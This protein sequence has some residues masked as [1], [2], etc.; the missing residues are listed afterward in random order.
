MKIGSDEKGSYNEEKGGHGHHGGRV[1]G[2]RKNKSG[3]KGAQPL[4]PFNHC[5]SR[6]YAYASHA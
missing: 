3:A 5:Y 6:P 2:R 1:G 4:S